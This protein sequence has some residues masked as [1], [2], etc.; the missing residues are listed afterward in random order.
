MK[1][2]I[3]NKSKI[4]GKK[5]PIVLITMALYPPYAGGGPTYFSTLVNILK[6]KG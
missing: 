2:L 5:R 3:Q 6:E 4:S 1:K